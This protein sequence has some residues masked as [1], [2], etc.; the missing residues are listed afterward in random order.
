MDSP[1]YFTPPNSRSS[2]RV[3][4]CAQISGGKVDNSSQQEAAVVSGVSSLS[5]SDDTRS[6]DGTSR[7]QHSLCGPSAINRASYDMVQSF[8]SF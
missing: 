1:R 5:T 7:V 3:L 4:S 6:E 2:N 8:D